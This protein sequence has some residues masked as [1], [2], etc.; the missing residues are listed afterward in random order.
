MSPISNVRPILSALTRHRAAALL[1]ALEIA[2]TL[3]VLCNLVFII[4]GSWQRMDTPTGVAEGDIAVIQS[5]GVIGMETGNDSSVGRSV[6]ALKSVPGVEAAAFGPAPLW[7]VPRISLF[8]SADG[9]RP[10]AHAYAF[11]GSQGLDDVLDVHILAGRTLQAGDLSSV[12]QMLDI[13]EK[14]GTLEVPALITPSLAHRLFGDASPLGRRV[15][16]QLA[17]SFQAAIRIVGV[18]APIRANILGHADDTDALLTEF[19]LSTAHWGGGFVIR[20]KPGQLEHVLPLAMAAMRKV[21]PDQVQHQALSV[22]DL[23]NTRF[24]SDKAT[25]RMLLAIIVV[26]LTVTGLG[27]GGLASFWVQQRGK[28]IGIRRALGARR[29][30]ILNYFQTENFLIV[31]AGVVVGIALAFATNRW[32]M[33]RFELDQLTTPTVLGGMVAVW[34]IGQLAVLGPALRASLIPPA[35]A[36]RGA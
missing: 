34:V 31:S 33:Q 15:Y 16:S 35:V 2:L 21:T 10:L 13:V 20:A 29:R 1:L 24:A 32:L 4:H 36:T 5:I 26:L 27:I 17:G 28:Q 7:R 25:A 3:A 18:M 12:H 19:D 23:R 22:S 14:G 6:A 11:E 30:D 9:D 8:A